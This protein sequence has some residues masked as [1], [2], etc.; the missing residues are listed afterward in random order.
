MSVGWN[1]VRRIHGCLIHIDI[2]N[3]KV[4]MQHDRTEADI[5]L[6]LER[7]GIPAEIH[8]I[9]CCRAFPTKKDDRFGS[10]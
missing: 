8:V 2:I 1:D 7:A 6:E 5:A 9:I 4:W 10:S 3:G